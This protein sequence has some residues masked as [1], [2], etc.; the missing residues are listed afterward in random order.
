MLQYLYLSF[1][2]AD[3]S[4]TG[5]SLLGS[6][7][8]CASSPI[9]TLSLLNFCYSGS[10]EGQLDSALPSEA[11]SISVE[12]VQTFGYHHKKPGDPD[13]GIGKTKT[14]TGAPTIRS[15]LTEVKLLFMLDQTGRD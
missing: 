9:V 8:S 13:S 3:T 5:D 12:Y 1:Q 15:H 10:N 14:R 7:Y 6:M 4:V 11:F 2:K